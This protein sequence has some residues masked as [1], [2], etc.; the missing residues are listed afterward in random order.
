MDFDQ[1]TLTQ[2][3]ADL[4]A[5]KVTSTMLT[6][7]AL[8][9]AKANTDLNAFVILDE[10]GALKAAAAFDASNDRS[11]PL[12]GVPI[13]IKDNIEVAGLPCSA[14]T[15][16]LKDYVPKTDAPVAARLR[17]AGAIIIGKTSM[18][19]LA[20]GIS[21]YNTAFKTGA[22]F[23]VRNAYDRALI[24]GG[25]SSGTGAALGA[26]IVAGGLGTDTGG[27]VRVPAALNGCASLRP[28]VGRYPQEG[29][30]PISHTRDTAGPMAATIADVA[31]LDRV[32]AGG[33]DVVPADLKRVRIGIVSSMLTNLDADTEAAFQAAVAAMKAQGVTV[34][35]IEV[36]QLAGLNGQVG[37]PVALYEAYDDMVAYLAHTG[38]G[39]T[40]EAL[41]KE[42]ASPDVKGTYDGLVIP[43][44]LPGPDNTL[45]DARPI[46]DAAIRTA[47]PA[48]QA[49]YS[50]TFS[51]N[52][53]DAIAFPTT[54]RVAIPSNPDSSS[55]ENFGLFIQN[56]DPGSNAG[57]PGI[58]LPI[59]LGAT[60]KLPVGLELDG[61]AG[62]DR[63]LLAIG[64]ALD[65]VFGR[66][67]PPSR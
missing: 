15:P 56:T 55:L 8:A 7:E 34:V 58:Q 6:S 27:S 47:R 11:K 35:E 33:D 67:P 65:K 62:S 16:A 61:P 59:A 28:T 32:I 39:L 42:I 14:G 51:G 9:R 21:G 36:P 2:A 43:R 50:D 13:V 41:A 29:I 31:L 49:L 52:K 53:L 3:A 26:R 63:R 48:L 30:A 1:L 37:F 38:T 22:E 19:E 20:F 4:R 46:Y 23:G 45:L 44:K 25:S 5:G 64:M 54:P 17:A 57:I 10:A 66:L 18:H 60:S 24:A 40:V 12:G